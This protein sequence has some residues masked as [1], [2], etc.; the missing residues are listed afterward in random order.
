MRASLIGLIEVFG[1]SRTVLIVLS[2]AV[3]EKW[4]FFAHQ[5][6][7]CVRKSEDRIRRSAVFSMEC[8]SAK[9]NCP[10]R[11]VPCG[12]FAAAA[13][14]I[15]VRNTL[16]A[17]DKGETIVVALAGETNRA[18]RRCSVAERFDL[19][20]AAE[21]RNRER[22]PAVGD[23]FHAGRF[24]CVNDNSLLC[25][26]CFFGKISFH[27][28][29]ILGHSSSLCGTHSYVFF[30]AFP[31]KKHF[32]RIGLGDVVRKI[33]ISFV[34]RNHCNARYKRH[35]REQKLVHLLH[36]ARIVLYV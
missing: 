18:L 13:A 23:D 10:S 17:N 20:L 4:A 26:Y 33:I 31:S 32:R 35:G 12:Q 6:R 24:R 5:F 3:L 11:S 8:G 21:I 14:R 9:K 16:L 19:N 34:A 7:D 27:E 36:I 22:Y 25:E 29:P 1:E 30:T 28:K 2:A 15:L